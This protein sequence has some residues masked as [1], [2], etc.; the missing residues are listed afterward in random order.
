[1]V[2]NEKGQGTWSWVSIF[3]LLYVTSS[4]RVGAAQYKGDEVDARRTAVSRSSVPEPRHTTAA[5]A[6]WNQSGQKV[7]GTK[8]IEKSTPR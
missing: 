1:M 6:L 8:Q 5:S 2:Q 3:V 4:P 7:V